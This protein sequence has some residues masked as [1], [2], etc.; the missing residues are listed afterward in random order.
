ML[1]NKNLLG[2][3]SILKNTIDT[4]Y[5]IKIPYEKNSIGKSEIFDIAKK[6]KIKSIL[7]S[8]LK[9]INKSIMKSQNRYILITGSLYLIGKIR[10]N[11]L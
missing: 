5:P 7:K 2:F 8:N 1:N 4:L 10:K 9:I 3:L 6:L 11:Y